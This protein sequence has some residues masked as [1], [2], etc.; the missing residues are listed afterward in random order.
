MAAFEAAADEKA[1]PHAGS[2]WQTLKVYYQLGFHKERFVALHEATLAAGMESPFQKWLDE[3][4]DRPEDQGRVTTLVP[5][6]EHFPTRDDA[7]R[8]HRTQIDED[9]WWFGIPMEIQQQA[10]PTEDFQLA[11]SMVNTTIPEDDLFA[12][13][14]FS[15]D[16]RQSS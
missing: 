16:T 11:R 5:C 3:W 6:A 2:Q 7:L 15:G 8:A 1:F 14:D 10:W 4:V 13:I 9:G 12:G